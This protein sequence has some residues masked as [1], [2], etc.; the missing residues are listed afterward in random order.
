MD[1]IE[2]LV[3]TYRG[4]T[5]RMT[6]EQIKAHLLRGYPPD[7]VEVAA[8][9]VAEEMERIRT[10]VPPPTMRGENGSTGWY[11]G[12]GP[13]SRY[14]NAYQELLRNKGWQD[15]IADLDQASTKIVSLLDH[16]GTGAFN[17]RG[18]VLGYVQSGKTANFMAVI[19]KA[20]DAG[21]KMFVVLSGVTNKLRNQTQQRLEAE[22]RGPHAGEWVSLTPPNDDFSSN[23][24]QNADALLNPQTN[25]KALCVVKKNSFR[26]RLLRDWF[27]AA[28]Q[29]TLASCPVLIIDDEADQASLN[30]AR[31]GGTTRINALIREILGAIQKVAYVGYTATPFA[32]VFVDPTDPT[33]LYPRDFIVDLPRPDDYFG[34]E[35]IFGRDRLRGDGEEESAGLDV[36]REVP[37]VEVPNLRPAG[38][39]AGFDFD[40][41]RC[42]SLQSA[43]EYFWI[44]TAVRW[45]RGQRTKHSS[46][47]IH[48]SQY[49][50]V[51]QK[52]HEPI[53]R[54]TRETAAA[55]ANGNR[56]LLKRLERLWAEERE[57]AAMP[58]LG[59]RIPT[60]QELRPLLLEVLRESKV[61]IENYQTMDQ[62]RLVYGDTPGV[63]I[64]IGGS[65]LARGLTLEGLV[66]SLFVRTSNAYDTLLQMGRWF[67]Y[68][69][70]YEDLP[71]IW[72][73][74][75]LRGYFYDLATVEQEIRNDI[76]R[77]EREAI[78][79]AQF[80]PRIRTHPQLMITSRLK[81]QHA[82]ECDVSYSEKAI[83][84]TMFRHKD[85]LWLGRNLGAARHLVAKAAA[86]CRATDDRPEGPLFRDVSVD[87]VVRFLSAYEVHERSDQF[88]RDAL[89]EYVKEE[90]GANGLLKWN[91][92]VMGQRRRTALGSIDVGAGYNVNLIKRSRLKGIGA[93]EGYANIGA[94]M[95]EPD[96]ALDMP[97]PRPDVGIGREDLTRL[98]TAALPDNGLVILYPISR[99]SKPDQRRTEREPLEAVEDMVGLA[100]V[101]PKTKRGNQGAVTY[102]T[103]DLARLQPELGELPPEVLE[104]AV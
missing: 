14:W 100:L 60:F 67:G 11:L 63:F 77:Y 47:L 30:A 37:T 82:V 61:V 36:I 5:L 43:I 15:N 48:S 12:P 62:D 72:I 68:R 97:D 10:L 9:R 39:A 46:M 86:T 1:Q 84:T 79:P 66:T 55:L 24:S 81:M 92:A 27:R 53:Q 34:P 73:T 69:P 70:G 76:L 56:E 44:A 91:V 49:V 65:V 28:S 74:N 96:V 7:V 20:A 58:A 52:Y 38:R 35:K 6:P 19:S 71:R 80:A 90:N 41:A 83:Q 103:A 93:D 51:H 99:E 13:H 22:L 3:E 31:P 45:F 95:S 16:P 89:L 33:D 8:R 98:R 40:L 87:D 78:T 64:V 85:P 102:M 50:S 26:L 88:R 17:R 32:N 75:E 21:Y 4:L 42:P 59:H 101:F 25:Q 18:L 94:L 104:E 29:P 23:Y 54:F 57:R 2:W